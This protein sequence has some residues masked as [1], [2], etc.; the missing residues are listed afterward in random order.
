MKTHLNYLYTYF[1]AIWG[2]IN[3][4]VQM[5]FKFEILMETMKLLENMLK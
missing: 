3:A 4:Q 2:N 5:N 1:S